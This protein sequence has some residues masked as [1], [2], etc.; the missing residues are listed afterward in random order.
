MGGDN[1]S[2]VGMLSRKTLQMIFW[3]AIAMCMPGSLPSSGANPQCPLTL[4][5]NYYATRYTAEQLLILQSTVLNEDDDGGELDGRKSK[6]DGLPTVSNNNKVD[7]NLL[8]S[9]NS[10]L[11]KITVQ[12]YAPLTYEL[13][14]ILRPYFLSTYTCQIITKIIY[15]RALAEP[16]NTKLYACILKF[17]HQCQSS[18]WDT[19]KLDSSFRRLILL[20]VE[21]EFS[22]TI[23][24][25]DDEA[26]RRSQQNMR[27]IA[28]LYLQDD[29]IPVTVS[30]SIVEQLMTSPSN[31]GKTFTSHRLKL[32][33]IFVEACTCEKLNE[34]N[35]TTLGRARQIARYY[36]TTNKIDGSARFALECLLESSK[37]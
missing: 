14:H 18:E 35:P 7:E 37:E 24:L 31:L 20:E 5:A 10:I 19:Y 17:L 36:M 21:K 28:E 22:S 15:Q 6:Q 34:T 16:K 12:S 8:R 23:D 33:S 9:V 32:L 27:F 4:A 1:M 29:M 2:K 3:A 13:F 30:G 11:N 26:V 25:S